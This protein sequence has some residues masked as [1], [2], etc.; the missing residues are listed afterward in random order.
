MLVATGSAAAKLQAEA[1]QGTQV[2]VRLILPDAWGSVVSALGGGPLLVKGGKPVFATGENFDETDL[3][4]RQPRAAVGQLPDGH[5][6]L[7][8]VEGGRPGYSVGMTTYELA[9]TMASLGAVTAAGLQYGRFVEAA[10]D[11]QPLTRPAQGSNAGAGEGGAT[12]SVRG[13][14]RACRPCPP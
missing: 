5:V 6:I 14:L 10:F 13:R 9:R 2:T 1:P 8:A 7:V 3:T 4:T 12:R 11:G